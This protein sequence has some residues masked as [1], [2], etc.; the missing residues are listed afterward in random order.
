MIWLDGI[1]N[2]MDM[3]LTK[4]GK[5]V[6]DKE[7]WCAA[8]HGVAESG[9][10]WQLNKNNRMRYRE[11]PGIMMCSGELKTIYISI[12]M[13]NNT[14]ISF[15]CKGWNTVKCSKVSKIYTAP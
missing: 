5:T 11:F 10:T 2:S 3:S 4:F 8:V 1:T 9:T 14:S 15:L 6:K 12:T 7:A 13:G